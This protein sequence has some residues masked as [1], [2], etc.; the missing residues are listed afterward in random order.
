MKRRALPL[1]YCVMLLSLGLSA[2]NADFMT[3]SSPD[4]TVTPTLLPP[5]IQTPQ[6]AQADAQATLA[7]GEAQKAQ[8]DITATAL[9][10]ER[11]VLNLQLTQAA[12][13]EAYFTSQ[14][15]AANRAAT[16]TAE[17]VHQQQTEQAR[18]TADAAATIEAA[19]IATQNA[20]THATE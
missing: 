2:C 16:S 5:Y 3:A 15:E 9:A 19:R 20:E 7:F 4:R 11:A 13:T 1:L 12:A 18:Q 10:V 8:M 17:F 6:A 14:T